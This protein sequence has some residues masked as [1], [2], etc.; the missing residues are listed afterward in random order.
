MESMWKDIQSFITKV[1]SWPTIFG[2]IAGEGVNLIQPWGNYV[3]LRFHI[4]LH[5]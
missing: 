4:I 5:A 2:A 1:L 3:S